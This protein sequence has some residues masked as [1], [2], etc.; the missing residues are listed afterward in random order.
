MVEGSFGGVGM[1]LVAACNRASSCAVV[2]EVVGGSVGG[3]GHAVGG[4]V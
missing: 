4:S 2:V 1:L 3:V